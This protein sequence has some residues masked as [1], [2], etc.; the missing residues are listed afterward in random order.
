M[1]KRQIAVRKSA[2]VFDAVFMC[3]DRVYLVKVV[4]LFILIIKVK[5]LKIIK[6]STHNVFFLKK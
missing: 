5:I 1:S 2:S 4:E 3:I 6:N